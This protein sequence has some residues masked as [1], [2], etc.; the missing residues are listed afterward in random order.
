MAFK[1]TARLVEKLEYGMRSRDGIALDLISAFGL[2]W[3]DAA[4]LSQK[5]R[6]LREEEEMQV[7]NKRLEDIL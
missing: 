5:V 2:R 6:K 1:E 4:V 7:A 3:Y